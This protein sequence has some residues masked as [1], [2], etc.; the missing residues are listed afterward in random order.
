MTILNAFWVGGLVCLIAQLLISKT[1]LTPARIL[2]G[3]VML[4]VF[5]SGVG[6]FQPL[7]KFAGSGV[8]VPLLG[9]GDLMAQGVKE[10]IEK[11]GALGIL[12]GGL[13]AGSAGIAFV[14]VLGVI[15]ALLCRPKEK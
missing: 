10:A 5:L 12:T 11:D 14:I 8:T 4:G 2:V 9:F 6:V 13:T 3:M 1:K 7:K 15:G